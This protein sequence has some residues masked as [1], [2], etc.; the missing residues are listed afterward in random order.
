MKSI[1][2][3]NTAPKALAGRCPRCGTQL[4]NPPKM[5]LSM[6]LR[7]VISCPGCGAN[8]TVE[9]P[10]FI[11]RRRGQRQHHPA[12]GRRRGERCS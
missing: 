4:F 8:V 3:S 1:V 6:T 5:G 11:T 2:A 12:A 9:N 10:R 7:W